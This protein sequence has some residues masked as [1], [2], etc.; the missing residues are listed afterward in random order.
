MRLKDK[1]AVVTGGGGGLGSAIC[2]AFARE[3]ARV[4]VADYS[5][6]NAEAVARRIVDGGGV[7]R[8]CQVDVGDKESAYGMVDACVEAF[9]RIDILVNN[10]GISVNELFIDTSPEDWERVQRVNLTGA[11]LCGQAAARKMIKRRS[12]RIVN[13]VS[14]S[15]QRGGF[16]RSAYGSSK[17]GLEILTKIMAVELSQYGINVNAVA[18][19][20]VDTALTKVVHTEA[21]RE[22]Y[23]SLMP[24]R[25]Y[26][27]PEEIADAVV[28]LCTPES[29]Y[30]Q[31][32]TLNVDG[33]F[34]AA[35]LIYELKPKTLDDS[36]DP[37]PASD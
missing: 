18:P 24:M 5:L 19:G 3:G 35:G 16:G 29:S 26:G 12:G 2:E 6:E 8:A 37:T 15:G 20:P 36:P 31:G 7:A 22:S 28:F 13:I 14:V 9:G 21:T 33:G 17:A 10:A 1:A 34:A 25:R 32:H 23:Y 4:V 30:V 27:L 11:F